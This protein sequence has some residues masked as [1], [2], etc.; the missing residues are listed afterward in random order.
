MATLVLSTV[1]TILGG[2]VGGA[3]GS[4]LGQSIDQQLFGPGPRQGPRLGDLAVQTSTY[5]TPIPR[6][7]GSM[8]VA[9]SIIWSTDLQESSQ[10]Q[11]A[12]GQPDTV[13]YSYSV[14]FAVA[15]SS[16]PIRDVKR[17]WADGKLIRNAAGEFT[18]NTTF[19]LY[20]GSEDQP[21]DPLI[22]SI[23]GIDSA[24]AYR[25]SALAVF[26]QLD[27]A[28]FGNR[29]PFLTFEVVADE[30]IVAAGHVL[31]DSGGGAILSDAPQS[32]Q[33]Y[34]AYGA[35]I[36]SA[37][38]PLVE[39]LGIP[40]FDTGQQLVTPPALTIWPGTD[41]LGC[42]A[43]EQHRAWSER[44]QAPAHALPASVTL[45][46][47]DPQ[48][49]Y[50]AGLARASVE[51]GSSAAAGIE[52]PAVL[53]AGAA[54]GLA[55]TSLARRWA[56][57][58]TMIL[59][60]P[61]SY[62]DVRPGTLIQMPG[63]S[64]GWKVERISVDGFTAAMELRPVY[65]TIGEL[66]ADPGRVLPSEGV[67][68]TP[69]TTTVA[70]LP[71]DGSGTADSP[72]VV[73]AASSA[74]PGG[75]PVPLEVEV[76]GGE[77]TSIRASAGA[78]QGIAL[79]ALGDGQAALMD[80][81]GSVDVALVG[82]AWLESRDLGTLIDGANLALLGN[83]LIQFSSAIALGEGRFRLSRLL[84]G[85][86]GTEWAMGLHEPG[87]RFVLLERA[88]LFPLALT[89]AQ[90]GARVRVTP[91]G[92]ADGQAQPAELFITGEAMRPLSP[93][94]LRATILPDGR[95]EC[96]WTRRSRRGWSW[97][98]FVDAPFDSAAE[99][100]RLTVQGAASVLTVET[101]RTNARFEVSEIAGLGSGDLEISVVQV[102]DLAVSRP[103]RLT[104]LNSQ[105]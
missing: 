40:L 77:P 12:K 90:I 97:L 13:T 57:R 91:R 22:A 7:F 1:G 89:T 27:L 93:V 81:I 52:L 69:T 15:L 28:E 78:V 54:K 59:R 33:G 19:R 80:E 6:L 50:Q 86:R 56:E 66:S 29:I 96:S 3:I 43:G 48:R 84:R 2:P 76:G 82:D 94:R 45:T 16:R 14:S 67:A 31:N 23:E 49:E 85:R 11:G 64:E 41:E 61:Q 102:G 4:L 79:T 55:E 5:G 39:V 75:K 103:A 24:P 26:E 36:A 21:V 88:A 53:S 105:G 51:S 60:L 38:E 8:R 34:A 72:V 46:Y 98:D 68:P 9:G 37:I 71:D 101:G 32:L 65:A 70:E 104:L 62:L 95:L 92:L 20:G 47:Y 25:G 83:E 42:G 44:S 18:V 73:V 58:D 10:T 99:L 100:Y 87:E 30:G 63:Q 74:D 17:I 35:T